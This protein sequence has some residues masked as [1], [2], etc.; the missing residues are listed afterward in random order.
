MPIDVKNTTRIFARSPYYINCAPASGKT[1]SSAQI[2]V[3]ML[4][5][6]NS[7]LA[8]PT[9]T[10]KS[11]TLSKS[12]A[13]DGIIVFDIAPLVADFFDHDASQ[14]TMTADLYLSELLPELFCLCRWHYHAHRH[15]HQ[16]L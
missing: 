7:V 8:S 4:E 13:V 16:H 2:V 9:T 3:S 15:D 14:F 10:L 1:I 6:S 12:N 11:Y 5:T